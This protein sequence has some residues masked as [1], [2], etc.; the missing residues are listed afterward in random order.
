[1]SLA[2][3]ITDLLARG[4]ADLRIGVPVVLRGAQG[5]ALVL[6]AETLSAARLGGLR[7]LPGAPVL[8]IT[9]RRAATLKA[10]AYRGAPA[11]E[12]VPARADPA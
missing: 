6:A 12:P 3:E 8:A 7:A 5:D 1:M 10:R 4:R 11:R 9:A 2:P